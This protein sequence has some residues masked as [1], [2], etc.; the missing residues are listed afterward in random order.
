MNN[1]FEG[2][3]EV[4]VKEKKGNSKEQRLKEIMSEAA[5]L[6]PILEENNDMALAVY[7]P[8]MSL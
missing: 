7:K 6:D 2:K 8:N 1:A 4:A 5:Q 3:K